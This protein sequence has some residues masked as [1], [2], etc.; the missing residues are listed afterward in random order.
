[1]TRQVAAKRILV[2]TEAQT[3]AISWADGHETV[4][5]LDGLRRAC[6]C[7]SCVGHENMGR[8]PD[9]VIFDL[10]ALMRWERLKL[11]PVGNY[12]VRFAWDDGH[13]TG[14]YTWERLR[15]MCPCDEC[16]KAAIR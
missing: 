16:R 15:V 1:M 4:Y 2:D 7:A 3:L 14:I 13:N 10:P 9:P 5:P 12:A 11:E 8:M 6:P